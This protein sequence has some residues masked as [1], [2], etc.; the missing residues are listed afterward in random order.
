MVDPRLLSPEFKKERYSHKTYEP[1]GKVVMYASKVCRMCNL[2]FRS[3]AEGIIKRP[4]PCPRC[5]SLATH[6]IGVTT[7]EV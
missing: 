1:S 4:E 6:N 3:E 5:G 7:K 2:R